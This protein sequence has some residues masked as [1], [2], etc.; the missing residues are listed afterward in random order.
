MD[1][2]EI[3]SCQ[4]L[5]QCCFSNL[6]GAGNDDCFLLEKVFFNNWF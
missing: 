3:Q 5:H 1:E 4:F 2:A 6:P